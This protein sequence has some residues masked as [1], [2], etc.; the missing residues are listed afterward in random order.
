[1]PASIRFY[2]TLG[3]ALC[4]QDTAETPRYAVVARDGAELHLQWADA[5]QWQAGL[6]RPVVRL[7]VDDVDAL[8][9]EF[10]ERGALA[11]DTELERPW[12]KP[13]DTPWG[14]REFH[15]RDPAGNGLHF[16]RTQ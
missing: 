8:F 2:R 6:D 12:A 10:A 11:D 7:R 5:G 14:T 13:G 1:M 16:F 4:F 9:R 3:F 15:L